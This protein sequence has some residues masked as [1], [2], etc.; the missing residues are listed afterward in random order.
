M[1]HNHPGLKEVI[2]HRI[3]RLRMSVVMKSIKRPVLNHLKDIAAPL[4]DPLH[5]DD[6]VNMSLHYILPQADLPVT[7]VRILFV[8]FSSVFN[9]IIPDINHQKLIQL[10]L[11]AFACQ[12]NYSFLADRREHVSLGKFTSNPSLLALVSCQGCVLSPLLFSLYTRLHLS[13]SFRE[14]PE[15][16]MSHQWGWR[17][18]IHIGGWTNG[19]LVQSEPAGADDHGAGSR[20]QGKLPHTSTPHYHQQ[21][22]L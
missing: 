12:W 20:L 9:T 10:S 1:L 2:R 6:E 5:G 8:N 3:K 4:L 19:P 16:W 7:Y 14:T 11:P 15:V 17:F 18:Y 13:G 21:N 22:S